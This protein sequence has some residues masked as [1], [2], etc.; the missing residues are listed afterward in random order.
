MANVALKLT[1]SAPSYEVATVVAMRGPE[2]TVRT[3]EGEL[4]AQRAV[5]CLVAP[6]PGDEVALVS[7]GDG[8]VF[9]I[10]VLVG[11]DE[12]PVDIATD[13]DLRISADG[14]M[15]LV[16]KTL[17]LRA[18]EGR[19]VLSKLTVLTSSLLA[20]ADSVRVAAKAFDSV[21]E[22][23]SQTAKLWHRK[24]EEL[25]HLRAARV[26]YRTDHEMSL[27]SENFLVGARKLA[28]L[29]AEQIHIG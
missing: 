11:A 26:D 29:D 17:N 22:R 12:R 18:I 23:I 13:G 14:T 16:S 15:S 1:Q 20:R 27:R 9:V 25:D 10:A 21:C 3:G 5:S 19:V 6:D 28:K 7:P 2:I 8:R 4:R 24:V